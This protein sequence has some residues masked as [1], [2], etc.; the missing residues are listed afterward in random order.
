[1]SWLKLGVAR[2][3]FPANK[4]EPIFLHAGFGP[5]NQ[6]YLLLPTVIY[7]ATERSSYINQPFYEIRFKLC[8]G[9]V[10]WNQVRGRRFLEMKGM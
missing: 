2:P 10:E 9:L 5:E 8:H 1:M 4:S 6:I 3:K 7:H